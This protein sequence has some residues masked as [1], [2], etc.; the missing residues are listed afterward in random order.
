MKKIIKIN[1]MISIS[2]NEFKFLKLNKTDLRTG[3]SK[4]GA[5]V[6]LVW[7]RD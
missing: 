2:E 7:S 5:R 4:E 6:K 1:F 3:V